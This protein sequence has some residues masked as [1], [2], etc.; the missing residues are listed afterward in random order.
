MVT[1]LCILRSK[2]FCVCLWIFPHLSFQ[3]AFESILSIVT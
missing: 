2:P 3:K 1:D